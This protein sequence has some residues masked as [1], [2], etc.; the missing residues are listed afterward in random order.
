MKLKIPELHNIGKAG[1]DFI[2]EL[3]NFRN[4]DYFKRRFCE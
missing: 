1:V 3:L 2:K 4:N